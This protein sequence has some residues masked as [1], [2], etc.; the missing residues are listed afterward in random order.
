MKY[1][2]KEY[3]FTFR[4]PYLESFKK[5]EPKGP[6]IKNNNYPSRYIIGAGL[7]YSAINGAMLVGKYGSLWGVK[8]TYFNGRKWLENEDFIIQHSKFSVYSSDGG[9][10]HFISGPLSVKWIRQGE[11]GLGIQITSSRRLRVRVIF[12]PCFN[13]PGEISIEG[14]YVKGRSPYVAIIPGDVELS[15]PYSVFKNRY[16]VIL[17]DKPAREYFMAQ[18]YNKPLDSANGAFNEV[19]MEFIIN[20]YQ[21]TVN[22]YCAVGDE[23]ILAVDIPDVDK[24]DKLIETAGDLRYSVNKTYGSGVLGTPVEYMFNASMWS[25]I[26]DPYL[27]DVISVSKRLSK[28]DHFD[29][30]GVEENSSL[31][32]NSWISEDSDFLNQLTYTIQDKILGLITAYQIFVRQKDKTGF[33]K[34][35][36]KLTRMFEP[37]GELV[38]DETKGR[39]LTAYQW[40][41]SPLKEKTKEKPVYSL[42]QSCLKLLAYDLIERIAAKFAL[43]EAAIYGEAKR[44]LKQKINQTLYNEEKGLYLNRYADDTWAENYGA[45]SFYPLIAGAIETPEQLRAVVDNLTSKKQF[46]GEYPAPTLS[47]NNKEYGKALKDADNGNKPPYLDYRGAITPYVNYLIYHGLIR[48]GLDEIAGEFAYKCAK[49]WQKHTKFKFNVYSKYLPGG[50]APKNVE[51]LSMEGNLLALIGMQSLI[52]VEY[53]R[54]DLK[55][56]VRFGSFAK[57]SHAVTNLKILDHIY[58]IE[59]DN[60]A[61]A[62]II[63]NK[64]VFKSEGGRCVVRQ[65]IDAKDEYGFLI[66]APVDLKITLRPLNYQSGKS[67]YVFNISKGKHKI[68]ITDKVYTELIS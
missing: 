68:K 57:G 48:Y 35:F 18:S 31:L 52:D 44:K 15:R 30:N 65:Y 47:K 11:Q 54:D 58:S 36:A 63:D 43:P 23:K 22:L 61:T 64:E 14:S 37:D 34:L 27:L 42:D 24:L 21:P 25:R 66:I 33:I 50:G 28:N 5:E 45:T 40:D 6:A 32:V 8:V 17:D 3:G 12:Y 7:D 51:Y 56:A 2:N 1:I 29:L 38:L 9:Y 10:A 59:T 46:W 39:D 55:F 13:W 53:F 67:E 16:Q 49:L 4:P 41:D 62:L 20:S 60:Y 26:Y 19:M